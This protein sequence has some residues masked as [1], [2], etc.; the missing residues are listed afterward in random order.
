MYGGFMHKFMTAVIGLAMF[1]TSAVAECAG[2]NLID[3]MSEYDQSQL[4]GSAQNVPYANGNFWQATRGDQ[5]MHLMGTYHFDD[6]RHDA[7]MAVLTPLIEAA[8]VV[9]VE[10]GPDEEKALMQRMTDDPTIMLIKGP[11][12]LERMEPADWQVLADAMSERGIPPFMAAKFQ[13][14]YVAMMLAIPPCDMGNLAAGGANGLDMRVMTAAK[15]AETPIKAL[16]PYDTVFRIFGQMTDAEQITMIKSSMA[17]EDRMEDYSATLADTY[18]RQESRLI[19]EFTRQQSYSM[20]GFTIDQVDAE[21]DKMEEVM[22]SGRNRTWIPVLEAAAADGP[23]VAAFGALHL[24]G[25]QGVLSLLERNG[26]TLDR[27]P[28]E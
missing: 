2:T 28:L 16:E 9:L 8:S 23:V 20:P 18:F 6:P 7:T 22:M 24:S 26:W 17:F 19:W 21:F 1:A 14:W 13:P 15:S 12:L 27:L 11:T 10:A 25:G 5:V 4:R 3:A